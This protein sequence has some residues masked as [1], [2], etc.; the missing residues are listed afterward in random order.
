MEKGIKEKNLSNETRRK[1]EIEFLKYQ[2]SHLE[3][4]TKQVN[5]K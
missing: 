5:P 2:S 4:Y 1:A 3:S